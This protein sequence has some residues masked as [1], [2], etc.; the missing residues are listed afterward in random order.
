[1]G[2]IGG[3]SRGSE[4]RRGGQGGM[5]SFDPLAC[6]RCGVHGHLARDCPNAGTQLLTLSGGNSSRTH[7][8]SFKSRKI[9]PKRG[10]RGR[11]VRFIGINILYDSQGCEYPVDDYGQVYVPFEFEQV[12]SSDMI[13]EETIK[14]TKN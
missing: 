12:G 4:G 3:R 8:D 5:S 7:G 9:G 11:H 14:L 2:N 10:G 1:M 6:Y 13:E